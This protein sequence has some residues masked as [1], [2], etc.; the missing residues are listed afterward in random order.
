MA[1]LLRRSNFAF[2]LKVGSN[3]FVKKFASNCDEENVVKSLCKDVE[4][5]Q[6]PL[7]K[8]VW[9]NSTKMHGNKIALEDQLT[10]GA[11][12]FIPLS[13]RGIF[14]MLLRLWRNLDSHN[15]A[16]FRILTEP[17]EE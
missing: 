6:I 16:N 10:P 8:F 14:E 15:T 4:I 1:T 3:S 17:N 9:E 11:V 5:Q 12:F 2:R 13:S 7:A